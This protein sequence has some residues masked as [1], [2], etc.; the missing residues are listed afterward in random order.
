MYNLSIVIPHYNSVNTLEKLINSIPKKEDIQIIIIDDKST[1]QLDELSRL[2]NKISEKNILFLKNTTSKKGAGVCRNIG[3]NKARGKWVLFADSDDYF[4]DSMYPTIS[5]YFTS[6]S[7]IVFFIPTSVEAETGYISDRHI[8]YK[9]H[10][11]NYI[12]NP[13]KRNENIL[14]YMFFVPWS[15]LINR[16]FLKGNNILFDEVIASNDVMFSTK[17][18]Y[19]AKSIKV[20]KKTIYCSLKHKGSMTTQISEQVFDSRLN[21]WI[22]YYNFLRKNLNKN[23]FEKLGIKNSGREYLTKAL[24]YKFGLKKIIETYIK[25]RKNR[26]PVFE[27]KLLNPIFL[28]KSF[29]KHYEFYNNEKKYYTK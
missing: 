11:N 3:L 5:T 10:I 15:K 8:P 28:V 2:I 21:I 1:K 20:S 4:L 29:K 26:L 22:N 12:E 9:N 14:R 6:H 16:D 19:Y 13:T 17:I 23:E 24:K 27:A 7:D 25:L 18:G